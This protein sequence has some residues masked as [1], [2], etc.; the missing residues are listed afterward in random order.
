LPNFI[1][2]HL[3]STVPLAS[4]RVG[5]LGMAFKA[6]SDDPRESLSYKLRKVLEYESLEVL[7]T[8]VYIQS[9]DFLPLD[10]VIERSDILIIGA[11]HREYRAIKFPESKT[12]IDVWNYL[13]AGAGFPLKP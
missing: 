2:Q 1:V 3:K 12:V 11:P 7:C 8:D 13:G 4:T 9:K 6:D 10:E 5:I